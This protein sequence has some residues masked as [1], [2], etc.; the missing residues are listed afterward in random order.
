MFNRPLVTLNL[1]A[2]QALAVE[3]A[4]S[5]LA[6]LSNTSAALILSAA[7]WMQDLRVWTEIA[8]TLSVSEIDEI[9]AIVALMQGEVMASMIGTIIPSATSAPPPNTLLCD[10]AAYLEVDYPELYTALDA[11]FIVDGDNFNVPDLRDRSVVGVD[12]SDIGDTGGVVDVT[13]AVAEI[14]SHTH[15]YSPHVAG[16]AIE[17]LG[18]P[19]PVAVPP[20][21]SLATGTTGGDGA[22]TNLPPFMALNWYIISGRP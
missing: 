12:T 15:T 8:Q 10:G 7:L 5:G 13:L 11:A 17:G 20:T 22:H 6:N 2:I 16:V 3:G 4:Y 21:T 1:Q 14:P 18:V 19:L 9:E